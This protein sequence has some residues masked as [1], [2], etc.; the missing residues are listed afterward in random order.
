MR[1][2]AI[3][4]ESKAREAAA[5]S[6]QVGCTLIATAA[7]LGVE[8]A[9]P[10]LL[11]P[12]A[13]ASRRGALPRPATVPEPQRRWRAERLPPLQARAKSAG[14]RTCSA[15]RSRGK[16]GGAA[17]ATRSVWSASTACT[18]VPAHPP[19]LPN[20]PSLSVHHTEHSHR[21]YDACAC[22]AVWRGACDEVTI[23]RNMCAL[24]NVICSPLPRLQGLN[25]ETLL[26]SGES[27]FPVRVLCSW[28]QTVR[29]V[30]GLDE[31]LK[32]EETAAKTA[33]TAAAAA[34]VEA[35]AEAE[36]E[37]AK[38][39]AEAEAAMAESTA[40]EAAAAASRAD[41]AA[42][43]AKFGSLRAILD[44]QVTQ[45]PTLPR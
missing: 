34:A 22:F 15:K 13:G 1:N 26:T 7:A 19:T 44:R 41:A 12:R 16:D 32:A 11:S 5:T 31:V 42:T 40:A 9:L 4:S 2:L 43:A 45:M 10:A 3:S 37:V 17:V 29:F 28:L 33:T 6:K 20:N 36:V 30:H 8:A 35:K 14:T 18:K 27:S 24:C 23:H 38:A 39:A 25:L 21:G